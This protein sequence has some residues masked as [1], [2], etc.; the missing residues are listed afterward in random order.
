MVSSFR[1]NRGAKR[2]KKSLVITLLVLASA[3]LVQ[4]AVA[5]AAGQAAPAGQSSQ[6]KEIK[7]PAEYNAY[8][9]A[10]QQTE[11][12]AKGG[13]VGSFYPD[14]SQQRDEGRSCGTV[15]GRLP[16][17][18]R[19][20]EDAGRRQPGAAGSI[21]TMFALWH[22]WLTATGQASQGGPQM[23]HNLSKAQQ[24]WPA[25]IASAYRICPSL[26]A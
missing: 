12:R 14:L 3:A 17:G 25:G 6:K 13:S 23:Q 24:V 1:K 18:G 7:D 21:P 22:C 4:Q 9:N 19:C 8:V 5:Q 16:A 10:I 11:P 15:D 2:M 26:M 20:A